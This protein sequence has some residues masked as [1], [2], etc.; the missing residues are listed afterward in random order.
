MTRQATNMSAIARDTIKRFPILRRDRSVATA[1]HTSAFPTIEAMIIKE[2]KIPEIQYAK[3]QIKK[4]S[5]P[6]NVSFV[7]FNLFHHV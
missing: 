3:Y 2:R 5:P 4:V 6:S 7:Q 1:M